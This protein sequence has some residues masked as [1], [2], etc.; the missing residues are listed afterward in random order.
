[1]NAENM[2]ILARD[3]KNR[4]WW[5]GPAWYAPRSTS[6]S[7]GWFTQWSWVGDNPDQE[8]HTYTLGLGT[9]FW[10]DDPQEVL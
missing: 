5:E 10:V 9:P 2:D 3:G 1:M 4:I 8:P 6:D 7:A